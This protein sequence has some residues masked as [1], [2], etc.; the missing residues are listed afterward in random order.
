M[1]SEP[2]DIED[3]SSLNHIGK[4]VFKSLKKRLNEI[5]NEKFSQIDERCKEM[6]SQFDAKKTDKKVIEEE[7]NKNQQR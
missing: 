3:L 6:K 1:D 7:K 4:T 5:H 2:I